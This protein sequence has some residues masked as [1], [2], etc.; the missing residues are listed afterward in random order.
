MKDPRSKEKLSLSYTHR[1]TN[2][3]THTYVPVNHTESDF[4]PYEKGDFY[5]YK[6]LYSDKYTWYLCVGDLDKLFTV[7]REG[8]R[9]DVIGKLM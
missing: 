9:D 5:Q 3:H 6:R 4:I 1:H 7:F 8:V 2:I